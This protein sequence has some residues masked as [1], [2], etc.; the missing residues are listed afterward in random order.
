LFRFLIIWKEDP[1]IWWNTCGVSYIDA[2]KSTLSSNP[3]YFGVGEGNYL[4]GE[5][6]IKRGTHYDSLRDEDVDVYYP[7][8]IQFDKCVNFHLDTF[9]ETELY[10]VFQINFITGNIT[11]LERQDLI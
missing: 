9:K 6:I 11:Q 10:V 3:F 4:E 2:M 1:N 5:E 8:T 7:T